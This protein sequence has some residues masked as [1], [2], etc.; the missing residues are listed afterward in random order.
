MLNIKCYMLSHWLKDN[1][2]QTSWLTNKV[3]ED[4]RK[5]GHINFS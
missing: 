1:R 3:W 5:K 2:D 4:R